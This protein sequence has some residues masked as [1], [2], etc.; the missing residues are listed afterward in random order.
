MLLLLLALSILTHTPHNSGFNSAFQMRLPCSGVCCCFTLLFCSLALSLFL[1]CKSLEMAKFL[2]AM[3]TFSK[4]CF[5]SMLHKPT[6]TEAAAAVNPVLCLSVCLR[7]LCCVN[8]LARIAVAISQK[9]N[10]L[11]TD[12][13]SFSSFPQF[14]ALKALQPTE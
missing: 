4:G 9:P 6:E 12:G 2:Y 3:P 11:L 10:D 7:A 14:E 8:S 5:T 1:L 13:D